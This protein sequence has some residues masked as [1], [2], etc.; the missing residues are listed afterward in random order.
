MKTIHFSRI[1][2][3]IEDII[4]VKE[5]KL[6]DIQRDTGISYNAL[7][8]IRRGQTK[9]V[10]MGIFETFVKTYPEYANWD[11][12]QDLTQPIK[13]E[14]VSA[15]NDNA[16]EYKERIKFL[17][18]QNTRQLGMIDKVNTELMNLYKK[19]VEKGIKLD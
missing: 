11:I 2:A 1:A 4:K 9:R 13:T 3:L 6:T 16:S 15:N 14:N 7:N 17:T 12:Q 5:L 8:N 10:D 19:L 18:E